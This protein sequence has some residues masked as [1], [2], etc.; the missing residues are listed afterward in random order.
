MQ[1]LLYL[2]AV[3]FRKEKARLYPRQL[4]YDGRCCSALCTYAYIVLQRLRVAE[5]DA[6]PRTDSSG[7]SHSTACQSETNARGGIYGRLLAFV[8]HH[9]SW[10]TVP[11]TLPEEETKCQGNGWTRM[12]TLLYRHVAD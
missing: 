4:P 5:R 8:L 12:R 1:F 11:R 6:G 2:G 10:N 9:R 3:G 7:I